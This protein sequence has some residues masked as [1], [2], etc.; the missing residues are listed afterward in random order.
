MGRRLQAAFA[1]FGEVLSAHARQ[2]G[3]NDLLPRIPDIHGA[4]PHFVNAPGM[5]EQTAAAGARF[6]PFWGWTATM[7][8]LRSSCK[9]MPYR[10]LCRSLCCRAIS[11]PIAVLRGH[12]R[13]F[14]RNIAKAVS[15]LPI[16]FDYRRRALRAISASVG[17]KSKASKMREYNP[18]GLP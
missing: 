6:A 18:S 3:V 4:S 10:E 15:N 16:R 9:A 1:T 8:R 12:R 13:N 2:G 7:R 11:R 14:P 17:H 5:M